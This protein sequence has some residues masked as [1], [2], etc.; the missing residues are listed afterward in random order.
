M[1]TH[2]IRRKR[3]AG[4]S[5]LPWLVC[6]LLVFGG[7]VHGSH[8]ETKHS[9]ATVPAAEG[10]AASD[11]PVFL[12]VKGTGILRWQSGA[13]SSVLQTTAAIRDLQL[14][15]EGALW[16]S[17]EEVGVIRFAGGKQVNLHKESFAK[18]AIR[19]P[20]DVWTINDSH[21]S[22]VHY[23]GTHWKTVRTHNSFA[24]AFDD[25][26]LVDIATDGRA[27]WVASWNGLW[28][29]AGERW[30]RV[31]PPPPNDAA[32][33]DLPVVPAYPLSLIASSRG[34]IACYL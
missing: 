33:V 8:A 10:R 31:E 29:V 30:T 16:A 17:L 32:D 20:T 34:L 6:G 18:L 21:G 15:A 28:R 7:V 5:I 26:H 2:E 14:D 4:S 11:A 24:G 22:V 3:T 23:D 19:S 12:F 1:A 25:N 9:S 13:V 27:V